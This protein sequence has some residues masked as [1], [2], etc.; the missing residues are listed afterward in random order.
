[1]AF[2]LFSFL[3]K[4]G[5]QEKKLS[6]Y[7]KKLRS[8]GVIRKLITSLKSYHI[9]TSRTNKMQLFRKASKMQRASNKQARP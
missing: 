2:W 7:G 1:M 3:K 5:D 8:L 6:L 9:L 4:L